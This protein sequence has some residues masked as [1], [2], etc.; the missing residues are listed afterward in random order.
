MSNY[1]NLKNKKLFLFDIDGVL[2]LG[3][4]IIDGSKELLDYIDS[5]NGMSILITNN[6]TKGNKSYVEYFKKLGFKNLLAENFLTALDVTR[7]YLEEHHKNDKIFVVGTQSMVNELKQCGF[8]VIEN[9]E[10]NIDVLLVGYDNELTYKKIQNAC[11]IL[12]TQKVTYLATNVDLICPMPFGFVPDCGG[13][14][15][16][17]KFATQKTPK[18]IG[19]PAPD[20]VNESLKISGF[21]KDQ[22]LVIG[23]RLYTDIACGINAGVETCVVFSGE[24]KKEDLKNTKFI[25]TYQFES[26]RELYEFLKNNKKTR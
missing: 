9:V 8:N 5:I 24:A 25:P 26:V 20:M 3:D 23:D 15:E 13:T 6:S 22:T 14:V 17:I 1:E 2:K 11:E 18:F 19:K 4:N 10:E 12:Q 16:F 21:S 7:I